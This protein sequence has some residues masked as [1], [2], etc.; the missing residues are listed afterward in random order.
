MFFHLFVEKV[1][2]NNLYV[3]KVMICIIFVDINFKYFYLIKLIVL[4]GY[5]SYDLR[6][7]VPCSI[8]SAAFY[9]LANDPLP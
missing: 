3:L 7:R 8:H 1:M 6:V 5:Q 9:C 2:I 4:S